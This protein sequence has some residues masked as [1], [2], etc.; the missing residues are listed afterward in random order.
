MINVRPATAEDVAELIRLRSVMMAAMDGHAPEPGAWQDT[1]ARV[2]R[3]GFADGRWAA[4]VIVKPDR[5]E[6]LAACAVGHIEFRLGSPDNPG[7]AFGYTMNVATD[8]GYRRRGYARGCMRALLAWFEGQ[9]VRAVDLRATPEGEPLYRS[10]G[11]T[12]SVV[13]RRVI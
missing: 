12:P 3:L 10:L 2:L 6:E 9:G 4:F 11:F 5:P 13:L 8:P 7:G 1:T